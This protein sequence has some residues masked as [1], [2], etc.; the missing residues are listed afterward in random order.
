MINNFVNRW[1]IAPTIGILTVAA[2]FV[3][4]GV[5]VALAWLF[6]SNLGIQDIVAAILIP[7][8]V[9]PFIAYVT[10]PALTQLHA[11]EETAQMLAC[12]DP[13][14][15]TFNR[16]RFV[17]MLDNELTRAQR[18]GEKFSILLFDLDNFRAI[19]ETFGYTM[20]ET[21]LR[22]VSEIC[23]AQMRRSD[24]LARLGNDEFACLLPHTLEVGAAEFAERLRSTVAESTLTIGEQQVEFTISVGV[25]TIDKE[26]NSDDVM[27]SAVK[28][29]SDA[30]QLG[31][32]RIV[33]APRD[34]VLEKA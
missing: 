23:Q 29:L 25:K 11:A 6:Q 2:I 18:Y 9:V 22:S 17:E 4:L 19:N 14:T 5:I 7:I 13:L 24:V 31:K 8:L 15:M 20:G 33:S 3:A 10:L 30:K 34:L 21:V 27:R 28:A 32:N 1:G 16:K 26:T 12:T